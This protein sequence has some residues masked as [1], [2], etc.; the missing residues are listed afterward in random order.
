MKKLLILLLCLPFM[1]FGQDEKKGEFGK[2]LKKTFKFSTFYGAINGG[3][4][5]SDNETFS[6]TN[7]LQS[8]TVK[9]PFDYSI[10]L[11]VRKIARFGINF[12]GWAIKG[13]VPDEERIIII[14]APDTSNWDFVLAMLAIFGLNIYLRWLGKHSI[15][16]PGSNRFC[17]EYFFNLIL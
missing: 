6:V 11:G 15:F 2:K 5:I 14:A 17:P 12:S 1:A 3:N 10:A 13:E 4:S 8:A 9:T 7:G 16:K